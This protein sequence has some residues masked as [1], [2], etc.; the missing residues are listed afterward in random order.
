M[1]AAIDTNVIVYAF[2]LEDRSEPAR[3]LLGTGPQ[4]AVQSLNEF[5]LV[6]RRRLA[7]TWPEVYEALAAI[8]LLCPRPQA[9]T[10]EVHRA[11]LRLAER[12]RLAIYDAMIVAAALAG[13]CDTL[14]SEDMQDG[15]VVEQR[16]T[17]RNP[18]AP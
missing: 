9:L 13:G 3:A 4:V 2:G 7:M 14:W 6:A 18:F 12:H 17:I 1:T 11:G 5:A 10:L 8:A 15:L 16:L